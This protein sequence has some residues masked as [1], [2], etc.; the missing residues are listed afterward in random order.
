MKKFH[1]GSILLGIVL[2]ILLIWKIG[3]D[4][5]WRDLS[6]LGWGLVPFVL[7][8]G[9]ALRLEQLFWAGVGLLFYALLLTGKRETV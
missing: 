6:L 4:A 2:L 9:I 5:L 8:E 1:V 3:L 7:I